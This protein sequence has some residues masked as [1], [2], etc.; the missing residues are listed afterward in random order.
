MADIPNIQLW[1]AKALAIAAESSDPAVRA[2]V[3]AEI[4]RR[5]PDQ[6]S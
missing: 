3:A 2:A 6:E 4:A 1:S 5:R